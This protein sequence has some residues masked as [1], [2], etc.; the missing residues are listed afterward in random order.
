MKRDL[1][2]LLLCSLGYTTVVR[3]LNLGREQLAPTTYAVAFFGTLLLGGIVLVTGRALRRDL[4]E[5]RGESA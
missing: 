3:A 5:L 2:L 1:M 4:R